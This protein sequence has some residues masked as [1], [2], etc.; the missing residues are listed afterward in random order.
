MDFHQH[1]RRARGGALMLIAMLVLLGGCAARGGSIPYS[2]AGFTAPDVES[3]L[4]TPSQQRIGP[5]D[6][7]QINVFQVPDLSGEF[8][9]DPLG[10]FNF[11]LLGRVPAQGKTTGELASEIASRLGQSYL[12]SP[13]VQVAITKAKPQT[14]TVE[15]SVR[16]PGVFPIEG[17]SSLLRAV[18]LANGTSDDAN[19][20]RVVVFR[21]IDGQ[22]Q[23]AAFDLRA[24]RHGEAADPHVYGN[25]IVVVDGSRSKSIFKDVISLLPVIGLWR[26]L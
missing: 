4:M 19:P 21:T 17:E 25:D 6:E 10:N 11:P 3:V 1:A 13:S 7:L 26:V 22:R 23:A 16:Q 5:L 24:I 12:R 15:G 14:I 9:V 20:K 18:A 8:T 2:P